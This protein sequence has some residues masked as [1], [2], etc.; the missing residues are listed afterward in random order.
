MQIK[1]VAVARLVTKNI[2]HVL[3]QVLTRGAKVVVLVQVLINI[4][5]PEQVIPAEAARLVTVNIRHVLAQVL[6]GGAMV[7]VRV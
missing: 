3:A 6:T 4:L 5:V 2:R 1:P 7:A